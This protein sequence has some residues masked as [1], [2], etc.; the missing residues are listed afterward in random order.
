[1]ELAERA[2]AHA[3][4]WCIPMQVGRAGLTRADALARLG[5]FGEAN[6]AIEEASTSLL[7]MAGR[8][9]EAELRDAFLSRVEVHAQIL[10]RARRAIE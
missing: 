2:R 5:R 1:M 10:E 7:E 4:R 6:R 8:I 9:A 3:D